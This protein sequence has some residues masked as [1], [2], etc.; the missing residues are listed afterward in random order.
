MPSSAYKYLN[1]KFHIVASFFQE[2]LDLLNRLP[3]VGISLA[4]CIRR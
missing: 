4:C 3:G 1:G 2:H